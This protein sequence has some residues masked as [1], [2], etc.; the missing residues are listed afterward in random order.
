MYCFIS[1]VD[2]S[3][4]IEYDSISITGESN[5]RTRKMDFTLLNAPI[6]DDYAEVRA[7][8]GWKILS[9]TA[10]TVTLDCDYKYMQNS[11]Y[12]VGDAF[13]VLLN[14]ATENRR[15]I[16]L[17]EN[18]SGKIKITVS[19]PWA[20]TPSAGDKG[21][22]IKFAG[23]VIDRQDENVTLL[24]NIKN[25]VSCLGYSR[26]FDKTNVNDSF[27]NADSRYIINDFFNSTINLNAEVD[28]MDY[29]TTAALRLVW[30]S[31][32]DGALGNLDTTNYLEGSGCGS[33]AWTFSGG[34][35]TYTAT[36]ISQDVSSFMGVSSG[37]PT[38]G[39]LGFWYKFP[40]V[41]NVTSF[42]VRIGSGSSDYIQF[43][44]VPTTNDATFYDMLMA[45]GTMTGTPNWLAM[46]YLRIS[47]AETAS[48]S[49]IFD[50]F[51]ILE[52]KFFRH[53]PY[54]QTSTPLDQFNAN[55]IKPSEVLKNLADALSWYWYI[56]EER[57]LHFY[58]QETN[59]APFEITE[60]SNNFNNLTIS[61]DLSRLINKQVVEG[62]TETSTSPYKE[63][64]E[65]DSLT[66]EWIMHVD[67]SG[68]VVLVDKN[69]STLTTTAL[70]TT[71]TV[72]T[73]TPHGLAVGDYVT[74]RTRSNAVR[75]VATVLS[76]T[77]YTVA[78][79]TGQTSGD[80]LS[81]FVT[82]LVGIDGVTT[83]ASVNYMANKTS[84]SVRSS[85]PE[86]TLTAGQFIQFSYYEILP[87]VV[88]RFDFDSI[89]AVKAILGFTDGIIEGQ[90]IIDKTLQSS[91]EASKV[92]DAE[93]NKYSNTVLTVNFE[94]DIDGLR[95]GQLIHIKDTSNGTRNIDRSFLIQS[96]IATRIDKWSTFRYRVT[97]S[98]LLFG[99]VELLAQILKSGR[100]IDVDENAVITNLVDVN[101]VMALSDGLSYTIGSTPY[102]Y[103][104]DANAGVFDLSSY[105]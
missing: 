53:Y 28:A 4:D 5:T 79:V 94:T 80:S 72:V 73:T 3:N 66:R 63:V 56:D 103:G 90:K 74:N 36:L 76:T 10:L 78:A 20:T 91:Y 75:Q 6:P 46:N 89:A 82:Q 105:V 99:M 40:N 22:T 42:T 58:S 1:G 86:A 62:G 60:T 43:T 18:S 84:R 37:L 16:T 49:V 51:R 101:E 70:T 67:Y 71:T 23:N 97:C 68:M 35:A 14:T 77:S 95:E 64:R 83:E 11:M 48:S 24:S 21:G 44:V 32:G 54:V 9:A 13:Y 8:V 39:V 102:K 38:K 15:T 47:I 17:I 65:G 98:T 33:F 31:S 61:Y 81:K 55:T 92:A 2:R 69:T 45:S 87:I 88:Q 85:T 19:L 12:R 34:T 27:V 26:I 104:P 52:N 7:F 59:A 29:A 96:I 41:A 25:H 93:L 100:T 30:A 57:Y 50:G